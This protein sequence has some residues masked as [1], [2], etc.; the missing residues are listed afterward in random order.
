VCLIDIRM[1]GLDGIE[2]TRVLAGPG[3]ADPRSAWLI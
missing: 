1:P 2:V 3:V